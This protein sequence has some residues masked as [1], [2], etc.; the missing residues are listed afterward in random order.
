MGEA[1]YL[2]L[3]LYRIGSVERRGVNALTKLAFTGKV[4]TIINAL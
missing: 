2:T 4:D 3:S 1:F